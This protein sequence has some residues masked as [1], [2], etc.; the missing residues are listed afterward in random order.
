MKKRVT[1]IL[2]AASMALSSLTACGGA[3]GAHTAA[4]DASGSPAAAT[5]ATDKQEAAAGQAADQTAATGQAV[6]QAAPATYTLEAKTFPMRTELNR[7]GVKSREVTL[8]FVNGGDIPYVALTEYMP[9]VGE[10]Y[11]DDDIKCPAAEYEI[12]HPAENH[13]LVTRKDNGSAMDFDSA[14]DTI[15][16]LGMDTFVSTPTSTAPAAI[17]SL[18]EAGKGG[19]SNLFEADV[20]T[21]Y[22]SG[23]PLI[24]YDMSEYLIDFIEKDGECYV[25]L[26][27][28]NDLLVARNG[29]VVV[30]TGEEVLASLTSKTLIDEMYNA[31]TGTMSEEF[32]RFNYNELRFVMDHFYGLKEQHSIQDFGEFFMQTNLITDL[33]G[34]D[35]K[36]FDNAL[37]KLTMKYLDDGH[38]GLLK[39]SFM[40]GK[41]DPKDVDGQL[42]VLDSLGTSVNEMAFGSLPA[43][44]AR[45]S[46]YPDVPEMSSD[47]IQEHYP[48]YYEEV[49]D[50]AIITFDRFACDKT[51]YYTEA[52]LSNPQDTIE[53]IA[54]ANQQIT[55]EDSPIKN[56]VLDLSLNVGGAADAAAFVI[57]WFEAGTA[58]MTVFDKQTGAQNIGSYMADINLDGECGFDDGLQDVSKYCLISSV[59]FSCG[60]L[61][62]AFF[63]GKNGITL[64]GKTSGGGT[65]AVLPFT[66]ASGALFTIS[67]PLQISMIKNGSMYDIDKGVEPDFVISKYETMYD[68]EKLVEFI[69][70][71]P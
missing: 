53:L 9:F 2:V 70:N 54:Y 17:I 60:N 26:Q 45:A 20:S 12:T 51:D 39:T 29:M 31:P 5:Q 13:T 58:R 38:S 47:L 30:F 19:I 71:L 15:D 32:A 1:A 24:T 40:A 4:G 18:G 64:L 25:P 68:R 16:F 61:V 62:P 66:T 21:Y 65:C 63:K 52:D 37:R 43:K 33:A 11:K 23:A 8:Y 35:P 34:T 27:T 55:R 46:F 3:T 41:L 69:H 6:D 67:S 56:V 22:R 14:K 36:A 42:E 50:T 49:G 28:I 59:S 44:D 7:D 57:A 10:T 48:W